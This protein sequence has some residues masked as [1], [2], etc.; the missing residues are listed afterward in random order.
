MPRRPRDLALDITRL[1]TLVRFAPR[2][3]EEGFRPPA[4]RERNAT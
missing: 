4:E 1:R 2:A 3:L